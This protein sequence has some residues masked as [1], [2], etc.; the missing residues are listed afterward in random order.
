MN[1]WNNIFHMDLEWTH[2]IYKFV[3]YNI[4]LSSILISICDF[5]S[6]VT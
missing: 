4:F 6:R 3:M 1:L 2:E 5:F